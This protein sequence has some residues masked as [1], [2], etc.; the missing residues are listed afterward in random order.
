MKK[1]ILRLLAVILSVYLAG[2]VFPLLASSD[3]A[4]APSAPAPPPPSTGGAP[5]PMLGGGSSGSGFGG[6]PSLGG[7]GCGGG[8]CGGGGPGLIAISQPPPESSDAQDQ[9]IANIKKDADKR[10][11]SL[12]DKITNYKKLKASGTSTLSDDLINRT[13]EDAEK[14]ITKI[15]GETKDKIS[16]VKAGKTTAG[17]TTT[18]PD[19]PHTS[20]DATK[21]ETTTPVKPV[22]TTKTE[23]TDKTQTETKKPDTKTDKE[24]E[25]EKKNPLIAPKNDTELT[26]AIDILASE[27]GASIAN[28]ALKEGGSQYPEPSGIVATGEFAL[29]AIAVAAKVAALGVIAGPLV[30]LGG[31]YV[32]AKTIH[33]ATK[34]YSD[35]IAVPVERVYQQFAHPGGDRDVGS[36]GKFSD[37][38]FLKAF[39]RDHGAPAGK[40]L[41]WFGYYLEARQAAEKQLVGKIN[42]SYN[43]YTQNMGINAKGAALKAKGQYVGIK[44]SF[45]NQA[46]SIK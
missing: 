1:L 35:Y 39:A 22:T 10:I 45:V 38:S 42:H 16:Q 24:W 44:N 19:T 6:P 34:G 2:S 21:P 11:T 37:N 43:A 41:V 40:E 46:K 26:K 27:R 25:H 20:A 12:R 3:H 29:D 18:V 33:S 36:P 32:F 8:G 28:M 23:K 4:P 17:T 13:I 14:Q 31:N 15:N 30:A 5:A 7:G 9:E